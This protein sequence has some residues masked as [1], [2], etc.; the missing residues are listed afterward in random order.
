M[1]KFYG[2]EHPYGANMVG[3]ITGKPLVKVS[4]FTSRKLRSEWVNEGNPVYTQ[5]GYRE[6]ITRKDLSRWGYLPW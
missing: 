5:P 2:I 6:A 4:I 1:R 3:G